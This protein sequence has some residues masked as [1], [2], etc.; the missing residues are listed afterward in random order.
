LSNPSPFTPRFPNEDHGSNETLQQEVERY[1][2]YFAMPTYHKVLNG[3]PLVYV[4]GKDGGTRVKEGLDALNNATRARGLP[5]AYIVYM[6]GDVGSAMRDAASIGAQAISA[7]VV[8][9]VW[10]GG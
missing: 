10:G 8:V 7:Y 3:R 6:G 2:G 9:K 5:A 1:A 4:L